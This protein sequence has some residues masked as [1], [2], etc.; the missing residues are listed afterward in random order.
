MVRN[1]TVEATLGAGMN[2]F[3]PECPQFQ[4]VSDVVQLFDDPT[5]PFFPLKFNE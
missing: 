1:D 5:P 2:G 4:A 3:Y